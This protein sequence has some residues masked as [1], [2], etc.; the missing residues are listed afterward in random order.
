M[1]HAAIDWERTYASF[2][3]ISFLLAS[4]TAVVGVA[5]LILTPM[6]PSYVEFLGLAALVTESTLA[7]PQ[8]VTNFKQKSTKGL[9][10]ERVVLHL[11]H[12]SPLFSHTLGL[13]MISNVLLAALFFGDVFK[14][15]YFVVL[16]SPFQFILCGCIQLSVD[17]VLFYQL[18]KYGNG[19]VVGGVESSPNKSAVT[20]TPKVAKYEL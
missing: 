10:F 2:G 14:T 12:L 8:A 20:R 18:F 5:T 4:F 17:F 7:M 6:S 16:G 19:E 15:A 11:C 3:T 13:S 9:R 1:L